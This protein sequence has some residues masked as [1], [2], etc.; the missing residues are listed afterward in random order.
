MAKR[1]RRTGIRRRRAPRRAAAPVA[2]APAAAAKPFAG[3][4]I[5]AGLAGASL[6][7]FF[8]GRLSKL[9][10][11]LRAAQAAGDAA[12]TAAARAAIKATQDQMEAVKKTSEAGKAAAK[13]AVGIPLEGSLFI[14]VKAGRP[15]CRS[16]LSPGPT[17]GIQGRG[18]QTMS[19]WHPHPA[20]ARRFGRGTTG[21]YTI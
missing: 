8:I 4:K 20:R 2:V 21:C 1:R 5:P 13:T 19:S 11:A 17:A 16:G 7:S 10:S 12:S 15:D 18:R 6:V 14:C 9:K 3:V